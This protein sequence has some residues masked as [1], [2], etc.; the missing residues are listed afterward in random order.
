[1]SNYND[2]NYNNTYA[3]KPKDNEKFIPKQAKSIIEDILE[4]NCK[5]ITYNA[6]KCQLLSMELSEQIRDGLNKIS[7]PRYKVVVQTIIGETRGQGV[8]VASR[9]LWDT[10]TD[11]YSSCNWTNV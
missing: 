6:D 7:M 9:C 5:T 2:P 4:R 11:N 10:E 8:R 3:L 1:M